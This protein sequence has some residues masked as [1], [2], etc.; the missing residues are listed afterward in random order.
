MDDRHRVQVEEVAAIYRALKA[1]SSDYTHKDLVS[2]TSAVMISS[3]L[4]Q[5]AGDIYL[6]GELL[7]SALEHRNRQ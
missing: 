5:V 2:L 6:S 7:K 4:R 1:Q 3:S